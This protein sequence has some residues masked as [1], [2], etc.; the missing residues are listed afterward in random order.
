MNKIKAIGLVSGGLDSSVVIHVVK[1]M[2]IDVY[3]ICFALPFGCG[4]VVNATRAC[5]HAGLPLKVINMGEDFLDIVKNPKYGRGTAIN[6][7]IDC[8][9]YMITKAGEYMREIGADFVF[10]GEVLGQRPMSQVKHALDLIDRKCGVAGRL[11]R[12]LCG[13]LLPATIP[14][15]EGKI[16]RNKMLAISGRSR[17][18]QMELAKKFGIK[19]FPQPAGGCL[20]TDKNFGNRMQDLFKFGY[21]DLNDIIS[22]RWGRHYRIDQNTKCILGRDEDENF[23]LIKHANPED[24]IVQFTDAI[25]P[26]LIIS[27]T[28][29]N[30]SNNEIAKAAGLI[31]FFSKRNNDI[32][33][34]MEGWKAKTPQD[35]KPILPIKIDE[36]LVNALRI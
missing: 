23:N 8:K 7:C 4:N 24:L 28:N 9:I 32:P 22:L 30:L 17:K 15:K 27:T 3:C 36:T 12:P 1:N 18:Q 6:P 16:D 5:Q 35:K 29:N 11:V 26:T 20:L 31:Q 13:Q 25:G 2:E 21:R 19:E 33:Q 14:E 10:T 34:S